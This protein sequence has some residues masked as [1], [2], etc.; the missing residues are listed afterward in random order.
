[1]VRG[2]CRLP[3]CRCNAALLHRCRRCDLE[4]RSQRK[5]SDEWERSSSAL[6][7]QSAVAQDSLHRIHRQHLHH[8]KAATGVPGNVPL[9][10]YSR[11]IE[12]NW[13]VCMATAATSGR[14]SRT[15][16]RHR[17]W[18]RKSPPWVVT[19]WPWVL[20]P[21]PGREPQRHRRLLLRLSLRGWWQLPE[22]QP[23]TPAARRRCQRR[24]HT[25]AG[26]TARL[27]CSALDASQRTTAFVGW[28]DVDFAR[29]TVLTRQRD[30]GVEDDTSDAHQ[31][32]ASLGLPA[33][34][35]V[36]FIGADP[37]FPLA[38]PVGEA[39]AASIAACG[40][41][42]SDL[43]E[44]RTGNRQ[45]VSIEVDAAAAAMRSAN[46]LSS[47]RCRDRRRRYRESSATTT[48]SRRRTGA[49]STCTASSP[50]TALVSPNCSSAL[51][52]PRRS[53]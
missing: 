53:L 9:A 46:Y 3:L 40:V 29:F 31:I 48:S 42:A 33:P 8:E 25:P 35:A 16:A 30:V 38:L 27:I 36:R 51:M 28:L 13:Q 11:H 17:S 32:Y 41:A 44:L 20:A 39:G 14:V 1:M 45:S 7:S 47:R 37:V 4:L 15:T 34:Q 49:G 6:G 12:D 50:I 23:G 10:G 2:A 43:W 52:S 5:K 19:T 18:R 21:L 22:R 24:T 26:P